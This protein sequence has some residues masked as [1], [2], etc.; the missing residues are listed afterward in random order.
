MRKSPLQMNILMLEVL[1]IVR[2][3]YEIDSS[4]TQVYCPGS[5]AE[6]SNTL[7]P[8][9]ALNTALDVL[10][11]ALSL[12]TIPYVHSMLELLSFVAHNTD[13]L[14]DICI[15]VPF[16]NNCICPWLSSMPKCVPTA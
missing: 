9:I 5:S 3:L 2:M 14:S 13:M 4:I 11:E 6:I 15:V 10:L 7:N 16:G 1:S 8:V 12:P